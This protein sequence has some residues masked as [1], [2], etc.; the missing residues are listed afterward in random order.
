MCFR[1]CSK[2]S[3]S[4]EGSKIKNA[5]LTYQSVFIKNFKQ[6]SVIRW[7]YLEGKHTALQQGARTVWRNKALQH[8]RLGCTTVATNVLP[9]EFFLTIGTL[10][11]FY[12]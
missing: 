1:C 11:L 4:L 8:I 5:D 6:E 10:L 2:N 7:V 3:I 9:W 12:P